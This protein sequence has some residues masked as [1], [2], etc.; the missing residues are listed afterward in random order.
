MKRSSAQRR[1][2]AAMQGRRRPKPD[3]A[4]LKQVD[5]ALRQGA[6]THAF[7]T[8][9]GGRSAPNSFFWRS[10]NLIWQK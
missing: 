10:M 9:S 1:D 8:A 6:Q 2:F 4:Q 5:E 7:G 3:G